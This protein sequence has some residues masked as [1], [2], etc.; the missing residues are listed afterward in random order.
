MC[1][2]TQHGT[3]GDS[4]LCPTCGQQPENPETKPK[5]MVSKGNAEVQFAYEGSLLIVVTYK[6]D[7]DLWGNIQD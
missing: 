6:L 4:Q 5:H 3:L 1:S 2:D 7:L